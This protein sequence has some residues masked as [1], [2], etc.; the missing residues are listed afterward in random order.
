MIWELCPLFFLA[1]KIHCK[2]YSLLLV[3]LDF[4]QW[5]ASLKQMEFEE[6]KKDL[7]MEIDKGA[8]IEDIWKKITRGEIQANVEKQ[9]QTKSHFRIERIQRKKRDFIHILNRYAA[10][11]LGD[12]FLDNPKTLTAIQLFAKAMEEQDGSPVMSKSIF[13]LND[14]ELLVRH[15]R[16]VLFSHA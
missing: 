13:K 12:F 1:L 2:L 11:A 16:V 5:D 7:Q 4:D 3:L 8:S 6:A 15:I 9:L 10:K 14:K